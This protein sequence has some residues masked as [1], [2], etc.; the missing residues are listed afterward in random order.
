MKLDL[1]NVNHKPARCSATHA[2]VLRGPSRP[3]AKALHR[4]QW[5]FRM[6]QLRAVLP[7]TRSPTLACTTSRSVAIAR[8]ALVGADAV[9]IA[10]VLVSAVDTLAPCSYRRAQPDQSRLRLWCRVS[11]STGSPL[12]ARLQTGA[13]CILR[14]TAVAITHLLSAR[15]CVRG[16]SAYSAVQSTKTPHFPPQT[17]QHLGYIGNTHY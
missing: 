6:T 8:C 3:V 12:G 7:V 16:S 9:L 1:E 15:G 14:Y 11:G 4:H 17:L 13:A 10:P 5:G 2:Q